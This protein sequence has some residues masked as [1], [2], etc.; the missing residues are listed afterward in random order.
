VEEFACIYTT[1]VSNF[2][3]YPMDKYF[4][5]THVYMPHEH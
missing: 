5:T 3:N 1:R 4:V 2:L